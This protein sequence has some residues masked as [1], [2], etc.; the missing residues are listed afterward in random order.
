MNQRECNVPLTT[1]VTKPTYGMR[2]SILTPERNIHK[3]FICLWQPEASLV[4][5]PVLNILFRTLN[6]LGQLRMSYI[7]LGSA[8]PHRYRGCQSQ[9]W[10]RVKSVDSKQISTP[11]IRADKSGR[12]PIITCENLCGLQRQHNPRPP[13]LWSRQQQWWL[14]LWASMTYWG[15]GWSVDNTIT[16]YFRPMCVL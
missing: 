12:L 7:V 14:D 4:D 11:E 1:A 6:I 8:H 5:L 16:V 3:T 13:D 10:A 2:N 15:S 9:S